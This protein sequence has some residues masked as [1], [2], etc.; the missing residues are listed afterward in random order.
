[1][2]ENLE[3]IWIF[4]SDHFSKLLDFLLF[5]AYFFSNS[6]ILISYSM[7]YKLFLFFFSRKPHNQMTFSSHQLFKLENDSIPVLNLHKTHFCLI[8][9]IFK[10]Y[11]HKLNKIIHSFKT[12]LELWIQIHYLVIGQPK[13]SI[14]YSIL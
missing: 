6:S 3:Q 8:L 4:Q 2:F 7:L 14:F 1:M 12:K 5:L 10:R 13:S 9:N 11:F